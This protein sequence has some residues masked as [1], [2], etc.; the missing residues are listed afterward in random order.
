[1]HPRLVLAGRSNLAGSFAKLLAAAT[2]AIVPAGAVLQ[3]TAPAAQAYPTSSWEIGAGSEKTKGTITWYNRSVQFNG[4]VRAAGNEMVA[5]VTTEPFG[6]PHPQCSESK[7]FTAPPYTTALVT[8]LTQCNVVGGFRE[9]S[10]ELYRGEEF[11]K[12]GPTAYCSRNI[13]PYCEYY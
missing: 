5:I 11:E 1:M 6:E 3:A 10:V 9:V 4:S 13:I 12:V 7:P 8:W 2:I